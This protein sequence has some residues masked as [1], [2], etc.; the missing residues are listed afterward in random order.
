MLHHA[1]VTFTVLAILTLVVMASTA[2]LAVSGRSSDR[3]IERT[4]DAA[5]NLDEV[6]ASILEQ[7]GAR[8]APGTSVPGSAFL[9][10]FQ[11]GQA[12]P[13]VG[14]AWSELTTKKY[15]SDDPRYR[16][17]VFSNGGG[18]SGL[19]TGR[20]SA[21]AVQSNGTVWA[22]AAD[23]GVWKSTNGGNSWTPTFDTQGSLSI[24]AVAIN[25]ADQS[26]WVGTGENNTAF[27]NYRG[28]GVLRSSDGGSTW[29]IVGGPELDGTTIGRLSFD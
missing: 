24:G 20:M 22:G 4:K 2:G 28:I 27:E 23:G 25:P 5:G 8:Y 21:L 11:Q 29:S 6:S 1:R 15:D 9:A 7:A 3:K 10:A 18:G 26:V 12:L 17:P 16:D 13:L 14:G 19:V